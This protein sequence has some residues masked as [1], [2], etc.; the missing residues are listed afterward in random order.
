MGVTLDD[1][2]RQYLAAFEDATGVSGTDCIVQS[3]VTETDTDT[4][5]TEPE[6][7]Q[8]A[9]TTASETD[10]QLIVV[11]SS[12]DMGEAIGPG[13]RTVT[14]F[15]DRVGVPV[16]L[17]EDAADPETFVAN[18]LAPAAVYNVTISENDDTVAYV[19]V[20]DEDRGV[21]IGSNGRTIEAARRLAKR[22]FG[23]DDVQLI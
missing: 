9:M 18:T 23:V 4:D 8:N 11:V 17:V 19:E 13:G 5:D 1:E 12:G 16:R 3:T 20:A 2:A 6:A 22:H 10:D 14:R 15:E 21:A 7:E